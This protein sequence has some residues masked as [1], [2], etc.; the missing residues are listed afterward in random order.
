MKALK[1]NSDLVVGSSAVIE[2]SIK[3]PSSPSPTDKKKAP[4]DLQLNDIL[5]SKSFYLAFEKFLVEK[6]KENA[7]G[8]V[9]TGSSSK[10]NKK[11]SFGSRNSFGSRTSFG[12]GTK[13]LKIVQYLYCLR[14]IARVEG[15]TAISLNPATSNVDK[16]VAGKCSYA[17]LHTP[18]YT[19]PPS[20][21]HT[22]Y[23][24]PP[25]IHTFIHPHLHPCI[26][27]IIIIIILITTTLLY[28]HHHHH[29]PHPLI[30]PLSPLPLLS[31]RP[32]LASEAVAEA[33]D[34][35]KFFV[36]P[37]SCYEVGRWSLAGLPSFG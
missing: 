33:W 34:I 17:L 36:A 5:H 25:I 11:P 32:S 13:S 7:A 35:Y 2:D 31:S 28:H 15:E 10:M 9:S 18:L 8:G 6:D 24:T 19:L 4:N 3:Q 12:G 14:L 29:H 23:Y 20:T 27:T 37:G 16:I 30:T 21:I 22:L 1:A 26:T